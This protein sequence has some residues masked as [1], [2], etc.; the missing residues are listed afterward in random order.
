MKI[1][2]LMATIIFL[3]ASPLAHTSFEESKT[4][5]RQADAELFKRIYKTFGESAS[6]LV[7]T[8]KP[9]FYYSLSSNNEV[10]GFYNFSNKTV[11]GWKL[12]PFSDLD[13]E[14][15]I[16]AVYDLHNV[17]PVTRTADNLS[18][19][20]GCLAQ[21][22]L[23]YGDF[24]GDTKPELVVFD[25]DAFGAL[26]TSVFSP[27]LKKSIFSVRIATYD[28]SKNERLTLPPGTEASASDPLANAPTDGQYLSI[29]AEEHTRMIR[30]IRKAVI[31]FSKIYLLDADGD[32]KQDLIVWRKLYQSRENKDPVKGYTLLRDQAIFYKLDGGE[33]KKQ[34][35]DSATVKGWLTAKQ[36]TW[37]KGYPSK[38]E[39]KG[40][41]GQL[42]PEMHDPLLNDPDVLK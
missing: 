14:P 40:Q 41:E 20:L 23:R 4:I 29:I 15:E 42:I 26:N 25:Q 28:T 12:V 30:G 7:S 8:E 21:N 19:I 22:S 9:D 13:L 24:T 16:K 18:P 35:A 39:C 34:P 5:T 31:N 1:K 36:L 3:A 27:E 38:S 11:G 6:Q 32:A 10:I 17:K 33:Y 2:K 37:Q